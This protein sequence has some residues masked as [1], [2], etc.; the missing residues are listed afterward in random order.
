M[1][2]SLF[3]IGSFILMLSF[4]NC[5]KNNLQQVDQA[6][7]A[8][9]PATYDKV[10]TSNVDKVAAQDVS[11]G[12][13][14][15]IDVRS[16]R[17][18]V[19]SDFGHERLDDRCLSEQER[20]QVESLLAKAELCVP[21]VEPSQYM[22]KNCTMIYKFPYATLLVGAEAVNLGEMTSGCDVPTDLCG[23]SADELKDFV[24]SILASYAQK[25]CQ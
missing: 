23:A 6:T 8:N 19:F 12:R 22:D 24:Q 4:Q 14:L 2:K 21:L 15:E 16:G 3:I 1:R 25:V 9:D 10:S 20:T 18:A 5:S 7:S 11:S 13:K 17:I